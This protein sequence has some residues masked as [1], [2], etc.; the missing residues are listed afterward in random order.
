MRDSVGSIFKNFCVLSLKK[1]G[2][3]C[4]SILSRFNIPKSN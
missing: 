3:V 1:N 4:K 2:F